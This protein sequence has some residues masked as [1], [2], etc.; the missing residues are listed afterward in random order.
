MKR[1][2]N[3]GIYYIVFGIFLMISF[4]F[5]NLWRIAILGLLLLIIY[6]IL[7]YGYKK[8]KITF[9]ISRKNEILWD[10]FLILSPFIYMSLTCWYVWRPYHQAIVLPKGYE[11][12]VVVKYNEP[13]GQI[14]KWTSGFLGIGSSHLIE[15]DTTGIAK[16]KFKYHYNAIPLLGARQTNRNRGGLKI[17][18]K[19]NLWNEIID[20]ANGKNC[21]TYKNKSK[22]KPNIYFISHYNHYPL[23][24]FVITNSENYSKYL[25]NEKEK[26][27]NYIKEYFKKYCT[28]PKS[29]PFSLEENALNK[30]YGHYY[31]LF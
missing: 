13:D 11:G 3:V 8:K 10:I 25:L 16:T 17:Y 24:A 28:P 31:D 7:K 22:N 2:R 19:D 4:I 23:I 29:I 1:L 12:I 27:D 5:T 9:F 20:G 18:Y 6:Y 21:Y 26:N 15:V 14:E 30:D